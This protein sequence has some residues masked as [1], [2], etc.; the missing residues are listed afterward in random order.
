VQSR[1]AKAILVGAFV[2]ALASPQ[3]CANPTFAEADP[4]AL[5]PLDEPTFRCTVEPI[6]LKQC[7]YLGCHGRQDMPFRVYAVGALRIMGGQTSAGRAQ[8]LTDAEHHANFL[9]AQGQ[10][11]H[12]PSTSNQLVLKCLPA[13]DGGYAHVGGAIWSGRDD[14]RV[15]DLLSWLDGTASG[16]PDAGRAP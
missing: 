14:P 4:T 8:P 10:S 5:A 16:C 9:S 7:S 6:F 1:T 11:F 12:T 3:G 13:E 15:Q 2:V